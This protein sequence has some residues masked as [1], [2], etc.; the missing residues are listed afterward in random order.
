MQ[1]SLSVVI[2]VY[3]ANH[4][5]KELCEQLQKELPKI[6]NDYE[7]ILVDDGSH[8][9]SWDIIKRLHSK[10]KRIKPFQL[11]RNFGQNSAIM[12]GLSKSNG[13]FVV[14][15]DDDLQ[16]RSDQIKTLWDAIIKNDHDVVYG[17][18]IEKKQA[19]WKNFGSWF[20]GKVAEGLIKKPKDLYLS[21]FKILSRQVVEEVLKYPGPYPYID[22]FIL[23]VTT[24]LSQVP[25]KNEARKI[26]ISNYNLSK[27]FALWTVTFTNFSVWPLRFSFLIGSLTS[28]FSIILS[29][30]F[31]VNYIQGVSSPPGWLSTTLLLMIFSSII[32]MSLGLI[33]EYTGRLFMLNNNV[34]QY[35]IRKPYKK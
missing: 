15:M 18:F 5:I 7:I 34:P 24:R 28:F 6:T 21:P 30:I 12:A 13:D 14:I 27:S 33:G 8:D 31:V 3:N 17:T 16:Q 10:N 26:G 4:T 1:Y 22:G 11:I 29:A 35:I 19:W 2:P 25:V 20:N 23:K 9:N 32:L